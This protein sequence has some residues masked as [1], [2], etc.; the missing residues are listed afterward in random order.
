MKK[1]K[2]KQNCKINH[3]IILQETIKIRKLMIV[4]LNLLLK[5]SKQL[6]TQ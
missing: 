4:Q 1:L 3:I 6:L 2:K 5:M